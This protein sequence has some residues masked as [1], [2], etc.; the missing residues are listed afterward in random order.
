MENNKTNAPYEIGKGTS[1]IPVPDMNEEWF[2]AYRDAGVY[3]MEI[4]PAEGDEYKVDFE[5]LARLSKEYGVKLW[6]YHLP[7]MPFEKIDISRPDLADFSVDYI[8]ELIRRAGSVGIKIFVIHPSGE[9]IED[10]DRPTRMECS[11]KSLVKLAAVARE[12]GATIAVENLP[13]TCLGKNSQ[14]ILELVSADPDLRVCFDTNHLLGESHESFLK[15]VG[16]ELIVTTHISDYDF[17]D[18]KHFM[19]GEGRIDWQKFLSDLIA[20]G[21]KGIWL[22]ELGLISGRILRERP[23][24]LDDYRINFEEICAGK[25]PTTLKGKYLVPVYM[26]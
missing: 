26:D 3:Y 24:T 9:P 13:R 1:S 12:Y 4:S 5:Y 11:K 18:E 8:S 19:P 25:K 22:Y 14:E 21:Y 2:K 23:F 17:V 16:G 10:S 7:F 20:S 15:N 6:S